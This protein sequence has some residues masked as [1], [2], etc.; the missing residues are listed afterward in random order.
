MIPHPITL[1]GAPTDVGASVLGASIGPD[2]LRVAGLAQALRARG[3]DVLDHGNL[4]GPANPQH[5]PVDGFRHLAEVTAWNEIV[6]ASVRDVL[7]AGRMPLLMG[8]DHCVA[9]GSISAVAQHCRA[10]GKRLKVLWF[11]AHADANT[12][13]TS[14]SGNLHGMPVACLL[15]HGPQGLTRLGDAT[16]LE[17]GQISLIG[18]RSVDAAEK[19]FVDTLGIEVYD[20][21]YIDEVG[22]EPSAR[23]LQPDR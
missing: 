10:Q 6:F 20:M 2:A 1:I 18:V 3:L 11:D 21:R 12:P 13:D 8:G 4:P 17:P 9:I 23:H 16:A 22:A 15:G 19:S 14:P 7:A 5:E